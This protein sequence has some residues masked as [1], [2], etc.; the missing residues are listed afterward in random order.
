MQVFTHI[1]GTSTVDDDCMRRI[2]AILAGIQQSMPEI[3]N[4]GIAALSD[5]DKAKL[6]QFMHS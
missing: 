2:K 1:V 6:S 4:M 5:G 3:F